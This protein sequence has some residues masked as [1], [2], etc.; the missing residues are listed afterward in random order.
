MSSVRWT[1]DEDL[2]FYGSAGI[3]HVGVTVHKFVDDLEG[4][5][6]KIRAAG[7]LTSSV[8]APTVRVSLIDPAKGPTG[9]LDAL[10]PAIDVAAELGH[11]PCYFVSGPAQARMA[12]DDAYE[13]LV[14]ALEPV[15]EYAR[16]LDVALAIETS[17]TATR[18]I[19]FVHSLA[20]AVELALALDIGVCVELQNCWF[21]CHLQRL[22][23]AHADRFAIV[24]VN[25]FKVGDPPRLHRR[26]PGDGDMP[27]EWLLHTL[28][29]AGYAG[30]FE[31]EVLGPEIEEEGYPAAL[32]RGAEW[33][34]ERLSSWGV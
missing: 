4:G 31:L 11:A 12:S 8:L 24:Q 7:V 6:G 10:R 32:T 26:V 23:D 25:D 34:S 14:R 21:D 22:F 18:D 28:L 30:P 1:L 2:A 16:A 15:A 20:D 27:V 5:V 29:D 3:S 13:L 19:G 17:S 9:A 33:I